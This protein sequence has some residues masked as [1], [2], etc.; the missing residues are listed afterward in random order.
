MADEGEL[1]FRRDGRVRRRRWAVV[2]IVGAALVM[3]LVVGF[4][5]VDGLARD[6][7]RAQHPGEAASDV[8]AF[9]LAPAIPPMW[10]VGVSASFGA[11]GPSRYNAALGLLVEPFT[12]WV[13]V[14]GGY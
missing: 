7:L 1:P 3:W 5:R 4:V 6:Y 11:A 8:R 14:I 10:Q 2:R 9:N 12:G 13:F